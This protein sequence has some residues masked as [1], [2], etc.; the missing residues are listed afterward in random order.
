MQSQRNHVYI[1][2]EIGINAGGNVETAKSLIM[3][4]WHAGFDAVKFQ[5]RTVDVV[6]SKEEL[7]RPRES[8]FGKTNGDLKRALEF[9]Q[10]EYDEIDE[11]CRELGID[12]YA[13]PW[14]LESL[15]FLR[16]YN[17]KYIKIASP[18]NQ[19]RELLEAASKTGIPLLVSTGMSNDNMVRKTVITIGQ[20]GGRIGCLYYCVSTYPAQPWEL[21]LN[22]LNYMDKYGY[23]FGYS[24]HEVG[25]T[26]TVMAVVLGATFIERH[27]TLDRSMWG[28][29]H[30]VSL[31]PK[32]MI[33]LVRDIRL[34]EQVKGKYVKPLSKRERELEK[35]LRRVNNL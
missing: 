9:G 28:S 14:D 12:W 24:G 21:N 32:G 2:G 31:E 25:I 11:L 5:K 18:M 26:S 15:D 6:Y 4:A 34:W 3:E 1:T 7:E 8:P 19:D 22:V 30:A 10:K 13:S 23:P 35:K 29:D 27:I 33:R 20:V 16:Q 17:P